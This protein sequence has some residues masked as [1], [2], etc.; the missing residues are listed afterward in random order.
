MFIL[1]QCTQFCGKSSSE[2]S[3]IIF[4]FEYVPSSTFTKTYFVYIYCNCFKCQDRIVPA[5]P[6]T[7]GERKTTLQR[8]NQVIQHRLV[9]GNLMPQMRN[10][11]V[12]TFIFHFYPYLFKNYSYIKL[13]LRKKA[14][15]IFSNNYN[16]NRGA[17]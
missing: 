4:Y 14:F 5:D 2:P 17:E 10:L 3:F 16:E 15:I 1:I 6:I 13:F 11:K 8:L 12:T 9:T 7:A